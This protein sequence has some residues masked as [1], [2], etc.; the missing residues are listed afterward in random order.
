[1]N[2]LDLRNQ[3]ESKLKDSVEFEL[4]ELHYVPYDFGSGMAAYKV[5]DGIIK[6]I[7][8]GKIND[9]E[10]LFSKPNKRSMSSWATVFKGHPTDFIKHIT[11]TTQLKQE[12]PTLKASTL[13]KPRKPKR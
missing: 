3:F 6:I 8:D 1:M 10:L 5:T 12:K 2:F 9:V 13:P 11:I 4:L 7:Y